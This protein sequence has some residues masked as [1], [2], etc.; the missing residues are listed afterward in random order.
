M[1]G[2][3]A[4][5]Q[6]RTPYSRADPPSDSRRSGVSLASSAA[7]IACSCTI[8]V[9]LNCRASSVSRSCAEEQDRREQRE[10]DHREQQQRE[11]PE[12]RA[13][14]QRHAASPAGP[15]FRR[16]AVVRASE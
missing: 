11:A 1:I 3:L 9:S 16:R 8:L 2:P 15:G 5:G 10:R 12:Q 4:F 14:Q 6:M 7:R 13:R